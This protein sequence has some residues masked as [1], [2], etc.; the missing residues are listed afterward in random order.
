M[1]PRLLFAP[2][3][4]LLLVGCANSRVPAVTPA[5]QAA[6]LS[7]TG[8]ERMAQLNRLKTL[9][10]DPVFALEMARSL[11]A[12]YYLGQGQ[13]VVPFLKPEEETATAAKSV[14]EEKIAINLAGFYAL[15]SGAGYLAQRDQRALLD[16]VAAVANG[17]LA[18]ADMLL[19]ARFANA[20]WKAGQPFRALGRI[21]RDNFIPAAML[22]DTELRKDYV[23]IKAAAGRLLQATADA[24]GADPASQLARLQTLLRDTSF[25]QD[26][27]QSLDAAYYIGQGQVVAPFLKPE[28]LTA[29]SAKSVK[30][31]KIA[32]NLAGFYALEAGVGIL[33]QSGR[34][35][36]LQ[37]IDGIAAGTR[38]AEDMLLLTRLANATWKAGQVFRSL[39]RISRDTFKPAALLSPADVKK[40]IDQ[41]RAAA[42]RLAREMRA[43]G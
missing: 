41:I 28:E 27:A 25:A 13:P 36:S 26:M 3:V 38:S 8:A 24:R 20:T 2:L 43:P 17:Q 39:S 37:I 32:I 15:E 18:D 16:V 22:S 10:Q 7:A 4:I 12:A 19:L 14:R 40:D 42:A 21:S 34:E 23:Q 9:L 1:N 5:D 31:E 33:G 29:T 11:D 6:A 35:T 30:E